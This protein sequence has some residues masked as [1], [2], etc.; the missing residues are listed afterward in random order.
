MASSSSLNT[1]GNIDPA[2]LATWTASEQL[3]LSHAVQKLGDNTNSWP[4]VSRAMKSAINNN[5][6]RSF[7]SPKVC[8][9]E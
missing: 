2:V 4:M 9:T 8:T 3:L 6:D 7:F 5:R 1:S